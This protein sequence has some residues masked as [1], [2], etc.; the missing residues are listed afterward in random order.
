MRDVSR[1][2]AYRALWPAPRDKN[3]TETKHS[4]SM[5]TRHKTSFQL[6]L[7]K[8]L[9]AAM[10]VAPAVGKA[11]GDDPREPASGTGNAKVGRILFNQSFPA[12]HGN[13]RTCADCH[14]PEESFQLTPQHVEKRFQALQQRRLTD[15]HADDP[16]FRSIDANDG[17]S[18]FTNLRQHGLVR[19]IISLPVAA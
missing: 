1:P 9:L 16:L 7:L 3:N 15:P 6:R 14:V 4:L 12:G 8:M 19:V 11:G 10:V 5:N 18:D 13:G 2:S 17:A